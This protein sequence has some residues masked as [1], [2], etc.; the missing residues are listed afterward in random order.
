[1]KFKRIKYENYRC[2]KDAELVFDTNANKNI[3]LVIAPN[4][5][6]KTE[7]L[8]SFWWVLYDFNFA[9][10]KGKEDTPYS[11][12]SELYRKLEETKQMQR[13]QCSVELEFE[14][15]G[16]TYIMK[17]CE[18]FISNKNGIDKNQ[19]VELST[20]NIHGERSLPERD[21]EIVHRRLTKILPMSILHGILFDGERMKQL[22]S[23]DEVSKTAVEGVIK[24][25]TNEELFELCSV[26]FKDL[27]N[28]VSRELKQL[29][30]KTNNTDLEAIM[31][32][33]DDFSSNIEAFEPTLIAKKK[34]LE[35][36]QNELEFLSRELQKNQLSKKYEEERIS[37][38]KKLDEKNKKL[39][40][41]I[42]DFHKNLYEGYLLISNSI[43]SDVS[44][45]IEH[46]DIP[47]GLT[48]EAVK[49]ILARPK[50]ICGHDIGE[51]EYNTMQVL[52]D[53]LPPDNISSTISEMVRQSKM[54]VDD[55]KH[56]LNRSFTNI[57]ELKGDIEGIK[58]EIATL[59]SLIAE[60]SP[61]AIK[62]LEQKNK[63]RIVEESELKHDIEKLEND[64]DYYRSN[65]ETLKKEKETF[66]TFDDT[67]G[68]QNRKYNF[69]NKC[70]GAIN[71]IGEYNKKVSLENINSKIND[72][73]SKIS[74]DYARGRRLYIVQFDKANK[75]RLVNYYTRNFES[76]KN[77]MINSGEIRSLEMMNKSDSEINEVIILK[78]LESSSTGQSKINTL[79][80][81]KAILDYS[82]E[83]RDEDSTEITKDYPFLIDSPFTELTDENLLNSGTRIHGFASQVILMS[84]ADSLAPVKDSIM[85][86]VASKSYLEKVADAS[87]SILKED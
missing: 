67:L 37:N 57:E 23:V 79:A 14:H 22:S 45:S 84:S 72:A 53:S 62:K 48:V 49:S 74:E 52:I 31:K 63:E 66:K 3:A 4:G 86:F 56:E 47:F 27:E 76:M 46:K 64:L 28:K 34:R 70:V 16:V 6:G 7:M 20:I 15:E 82:N 13:F 59:S 12:N 87:Y 24:H 78:V 40:A 61:E 21:Q 50:C 2:F 5:G 75:Y 58:K 85:P 73:Y 11:L 65:I 35:V 80:F 30:K 69:I 60:G 41:A 68:F 44:E 32:K 26:E 81:A 38:R 8:F 25:I 42:D 55:V 33:I 71:E 83:R 51:E 19:T 39:D 17:R 29:A 1:M 77:N 43:F 54:H 10:L 18:A 36:V 9:D